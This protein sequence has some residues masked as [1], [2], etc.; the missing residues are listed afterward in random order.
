M[1]LQ[2]VAHNTHLHAGGCAEFHKRSND[3]QKPGEIQDQYLIMA[4]GLG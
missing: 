1:Q 4:I 3:W 2:P